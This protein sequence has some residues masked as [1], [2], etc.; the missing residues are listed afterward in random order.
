MTYGPVSQCSV[1]ARFVSPWASPNSQPTCEAFPQGI[2]QSVLDN[3]LD[4]REPVEGDN[5]IRWQSDGRPYPD[6]D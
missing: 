4:H 6:L 1:C 5:G 3:T 2:P